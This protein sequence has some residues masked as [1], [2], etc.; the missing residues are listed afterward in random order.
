[1]TSK[2]EINQKNHLGKWSV[3][4]YFAAGAVIQS[5]SEAI[6][7]TGNYDPEKFPLGWESFNLLEEVLEGGIAMGLGALAGKII[8]ALKIE[9]GGEEYSPIAEAWWIGMGGLLSYGSMAAILGPL[10][11]ELAGVPDVKWGP[12]Q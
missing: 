4:Y 1:M 3:I 8:Y 10:I 5:F 12:F 11:H 9:K 2:E 6:K 7:I